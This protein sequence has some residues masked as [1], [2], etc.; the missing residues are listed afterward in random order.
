MTASAN[1]VWS[2]Y[3]LDGDVDLYVSTNTHG[4]SPPELLGRNTLWSNNGDGTFTDVTQAAGLDLTASPSRHSTFLDMDNDGDFDL[5][6][7]NMG[8]PNVVWRNRLMEIGSPVFVDVTTQASPGAEDLSH[9][10]DS[11]ASGA[12]DFNKPRWSPGIRTRW[13]TR[14]SSTCRERAFRTS[15]RRPMSSRAFLQPRV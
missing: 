5:F 13:A 10:R 14:S 1:G 6:E 15:R 3:D 8:A 7:N 9:P 4:D 12:V 2:D 11:F